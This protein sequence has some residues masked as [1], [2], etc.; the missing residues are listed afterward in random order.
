MSQKTK[1]ET[2]AMVAESKHSK[3]YD[4]IVVGAGPAG[5]CAAA[6]L[7][8]QGLDILVIEKQKFPR[9]VIGES[10]LPQCMV[11]LEKAGLL[12]A[13][14][15]AGFQVKDGA[16]F[17]MG[18]STS[19]IYFEK[20]FSEGPY[21]TFQVIR[22][23][24]DHVLIKEAERFGAEVRFETEL[25]AI[26]FLDECELDIFDEKTQSSDMVRGKFVFDASGYGKTLPRL[27]NLSKPADFPVRNASF[28]HVRNDLRD[29]TV[30]DN[31]ILIAIHPEIRDVWYWLIPFTNNIA[32]AGVIY[33]PHLAET[34]ATPNDAWDTLMAQS[35]NMSR[36]LVH[37]EKVREV[38]CISGYAW[39]TDKQYGDRYC[40]MGNTAGFL[41]PVF[42][43]GVTIALMSAIKAC[44]VFVA[45]LNGESA[46]WE[47]YEE[48]VNRGLN[49]FSAY[50]NAWYD[51]S[52]QDV[53]FYNHPEER[54]VS[55]ITS[56]LAGYAWDE[57][58][59]YT[60]EAAKRLKILHNLC[61]T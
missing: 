6:Y 42:S 61:S 5:S 60:V 19:T 20:K 12:P 40:L 24:F 16:L 1:K 11:A 49:V 56:V 43:S 31:K 8:N 29:E 27:L 52:F 55:L 51:Q 21:S 13:V 15:K 2:A 36:R 23:D 39:S 9:F 3:I 59:L 37:A 32:S 58:N 46:N 7:A 41:D 47:E 4:A 17:E 54:T 33:P 53:L 22:S 38:N 25:R 57:K 28:T 35:P 30:D 26:R 10:L 44:E 50:V 18:D 45:S 34:F 48:Y 14:Q